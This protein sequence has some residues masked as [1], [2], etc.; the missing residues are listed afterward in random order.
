MDKLKIEITG[1]PLFKIL[2]PL[3]DKQESMQYGVLNFTELKCIGKWVNG[4]LE[5]QHGK[6]RA[7]YV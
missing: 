5:E 7:D 6:E 1:L 4:F 2:K 3:S